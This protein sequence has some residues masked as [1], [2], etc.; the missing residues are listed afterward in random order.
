MKSIYFLNTYYS[1]DIT[2]TSYF[3][4]RMTWYI[5]TFFFFLFLQIHLKYESEIYDIIIMKAK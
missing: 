4:Q 2:E 3:S 5:M 1:S